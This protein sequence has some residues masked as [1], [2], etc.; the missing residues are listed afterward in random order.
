MRTFQV[1]GKLQ[2]DVQD[3][4]N[5]VEIPPVPIDLDRAGRHDLGVKGNHNLVG[6]LAVIEGVQVNGPD[7][8]EWLVTRRYLDLGLPVR[9]SNVSAILPVTLPNHQ[10]EALKPCSQGNIMLFLSNFQKVCSFFSLISSFQFNQFL[11]NLPNAQD[12]RILIIQ[13]RIE[14]LGS[15]VLKLVNL[16]FFMTSPHLQVSPPSKF[17]S[18]LF[19]PLMKWIWGTWYSL[20]RK[21]QLW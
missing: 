18:A 11:D 1:H 14:S 16:T 6:E 12:Y 15:D 2:I 20:F 13:L 17:R 10:P 21:F 3:S 7:P 8:W 9:W 19:Q 5:V 4:I